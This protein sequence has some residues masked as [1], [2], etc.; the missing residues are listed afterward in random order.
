MIR[1]LYTW[2]R[3]GHWN[4]DVL[5]TCKRSPEVT[6]WI[7]KSEP[8]CGKKVLTKKIFDFE[9]EI[10]IPWRS[11]LYERITPEGMSDPEVPNMAA[12]EMKTISYDRKSF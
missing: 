12:W 5:N 7:V 1:H 11:F 3:V 10:Y 8:I 9:F 2:P 4:S 6:S